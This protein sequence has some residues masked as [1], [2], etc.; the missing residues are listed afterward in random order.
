MITKKYIS[1]VFFLCLIIFSTD[2]SFGQNPDTS[3]YFP[4]HL[5]DVWEY[6]KFDYILLTFDTTQIKILNDSTDIS[7]NS[8]IM[9]EQYLINPHNLE[10][11]TGFIIDTSG[12]IYKTNL[13]YRDSVLIY[14]ESAQQGDKWIGQL[15]GGPSAIMC[16]LKNVYIDTILGFPSKS[17]EIWYYGASDTSDTT[18]WLAWYI[19]IFSSG[20]GMT[21]FGGFETFFDMNLKGALIDN[22]LY[23]DTTYITI[24]KREND[25]IIPSQLQLNQNY[26]NPF[27]GQTNISFKLKN[28][29]YITMSIYNLLGQE[30]IRL[31]D[32]RFFYNGEF[33]V[34]WNGV[35]KNGKTLPSGEYWCLLKSNEQISIKKLILLK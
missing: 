6:Y 30:I 23:G 29:Y 14:K 8:Y 2:K 31:I 27:N 22:I 9:T 26:P 12:N 10:T 16:E 21:Y 4:H 33:N 34:T 24:I 15:L 17:K 20:F 13:L 28:P 5:G 25:F 11:K 3:N 32:N 1:I 19:R 18:V 7:G 35:D